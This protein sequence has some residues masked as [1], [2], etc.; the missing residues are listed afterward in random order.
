[1]PVQYDPFYAAPVKRDFD[2]VEVDDELH[3]RLRSMN[4]LNFPCQSSREHHS[5][6]VLRPLSN[7]AILFPQSVLFIY[8]NVH[9]EIL[10]YDNIKRG[11]DVGIDGRVN[12]YSDEPWLMRARFWGL[13]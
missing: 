1:M 3:I 4:S 7:F 6:K 5:T 9:N 11:F 2:R 13:D 12:A 10:V 8:S